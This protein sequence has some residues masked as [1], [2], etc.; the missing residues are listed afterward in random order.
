MCLMDGRCKQINI[1][2][3]KRVLSNTVMNDS[4]LIFNLHIN[5]KNINFF[6]FGGKLIIIKTS[7]LKRLLNNLN[8]VLVLIV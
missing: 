8:K 7:E 3:L 1:N 2:L 5:I 6:L 4:L